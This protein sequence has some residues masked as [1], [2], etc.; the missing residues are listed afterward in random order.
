MHTK[1][2]Q[3]ILKRFITKEIEKVYKKYNTI[4]V[5]EAELVVRFIEKI[6][7]NKT[8]YNP[9]LDYNNTKKLAEALERENNIDVIRLCILIIADIELDIKLEE[10]KEIYKK[11]EGKGYVQIDKHLIYYDYAER[12]LETLAENT[13]EEELEDVEKVME[14]FDE[15]E[16]ANMWIFQI[17]MS[18]VSQQYVR[19]NGWEEVLGIEDVEEGY[20]DSHNVQVYYGL[21]ERGEIL[22]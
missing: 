15:E 22:E 2:N 3:V 13:L 8:D 4:T 19:D 17:S 14:L 10:V 11:L 9:Y 6:E 5:E 1:D 16:V 7:G 18:S 12:E 21:N 20:V